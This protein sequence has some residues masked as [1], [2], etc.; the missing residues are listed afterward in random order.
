MKL[1]KIHRALGFAQSTWLKSYI[2]FNTEKRKQASNDFEKDFFKL[3]NNAVFGKTMENLRKRVNVKPVTNP[4]KLNKLTASPAFDAFRIFSEDLAAICMKKTNL[5][6]NRPIYV[7]FMILDLSKVLMYD[8]LSNYMV[9]KYG[10]QAKLLFTDTDSLCYDVNTDDLY[11]DFLQDLDYF[12]TSEYP[13]DHFLYSAR[14]KMV[15]G[16]MKDETHGIPIE[17]FVGFR[18]KMYSILFTEDSNQVEKKTAKGIS[19]NVTKR[20]IRHQDYKTCLFEK[21]VQMARMN[22]IRS[23]NHQIYSLTLTKTSL[24]PYDDKRFILA[25]G[26]HTRLWTLFD[27]C[28]LRVDSNVNKFPHEYI[29]VIYNFTTNVVNF[30][31]NSS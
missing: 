9:S 8:F 25:D 11:H 16:K 7:G 15:L 18:P 6:L 3:M 14:N 10:P 26:C 13:R 27:C 17:E 29:F 22:Q 31:I 28:M 20:K 19:K 24:S 23:E 21:Q 1:T 5:H 4:S 12:D 30:S 2:D